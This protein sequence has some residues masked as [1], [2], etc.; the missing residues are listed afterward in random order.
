MKFLSLVEDKSLEETRFIP[1]N[2]FSLNIPTE[3]S[4]SR[5]ASWEIAK[6]SLKERPMFGSGLSTFYYS[7]NKYKDIGLN[8]TGLWNI[9]FDNATGLFFESLVTLGIVGTLVILV[10]LLIGAVLSFSALLKTKDE[11]YAPI[12]LGLCT[13]FIF[14]FIFSFLFSF[15][16]ALIIYAILISFLC[17]SASIV[18][19]EQK[20][21]ALK[22]TFQSRE[23]Y[24][25]LIAFLAAFIVIVALIILGFK[26]YLADVYAKKSMEATKVSD[27]ISKLEKAVKLGFSQDGY[28][29]GLSNYYVLLSN[30]AANQGDKDIAQTNLAKALELGKKAV[31]IAPN[32]SRNNQSL[33]LL[34]ESSYLYD[35]S[36]LEKA[37]SQYKK[38]I[39]L[40]PNN[41][42]PYLRLG[43]IRM[44]QANSET[45]AEEK[46][47]FIEEAIKQYNEALKR[48]D[49][50]TDAY[51]GK[52]I[53]Y[54]NLGDVEQAIQNLIKASNIDPNNET[55]RFELARLYFNKGI[56]QDDTPQDLSGLT[57]QE[58][59]ILQIRKSRGLIEP[60]KDLKAAEQLFLSVLLENQKHANARY[61]LALLYQK[62]GD[63]EKASVMVKSLIN[64]LE[65][66]EQK[67]VIRKQ[68]PGLY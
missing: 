35:K 21:Q 24:K 60:N 68:F 53:A 49:N 65:D 25:L 40:E 22:L 2:I 45:E 31:D 15:S 27:K 47:Y 19:S 36:A 6:N 61:S 20:L 52:S 66:E 67:E 9:G 64:I 4:L 57:E 8:K 58:L 38:V 14:V 7:F 3:V 23:R 32:K 29:L 16:P 51:Q 26:M 39:E 12:L 30:Q 50:L 11:A 55:Y 54:E 59:R 28:Y 5:S 18:F 17:F 37:E 43:L 34:Y 33:A 41:P 10:I 48:K 62:I 1:D 44:A 46:K 42:T 13:S 56:A 63:V